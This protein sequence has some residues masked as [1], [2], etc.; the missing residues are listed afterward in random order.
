MKI[1]IKLP[2]NRGSWIWL[3]VLMLTACSPAAPATFPPTVIP[4][5][6]STPQTVS[7][8]AQVQRVEVQM[9]PTNPSQASAVVHG[10]L[11]ESCAKLG[12]SQVQYALHTFQIRVYAL[13]P[14][15]IG[16][17]PV[18]TPF[19]TIIPLDTKD[20]PAGRYTIIANGVY[21]AFTIPEEDPTATSI[22][23]VIV[24]P[25]GVTCSD[26]ATF[27]SD[28]TI[29]DNSLLG[30]NAA[31]KKTW[32]VKNTGTCTWD[33]SYLVAY[34]SGATM[35]QQPGYWI[36]PPGQTVAPGQTADVSV[37]MTSPVDNGNYVAYWGL[38]KVNG[39]FMPVAGGANGN[40]FYVKIKVSNGTPEG[41]I[42]AQSI[43]I[44]LEQGS[45]AVCTANSTY[46]VNA[47]ITAN[48]PAAASYEINSTAGQIA[49]GN[50]QSSP[51]GPVGPVVTGTLVFDQADTKTI[52]YRFVGP[53][54]Y[55]NDITINLKVNDGEWQ[56]TKLSCQ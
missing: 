6:T 30:P 16:C 35:S 1:I 21:A 52:N 28:V 53:Y 20:L 31:F 40:S 37:G 49:A 11:T 47:S 15:D 9:S 38:K 2:L 32:R 39:P 26:S 19:E 46:F 36:V 51:T 5:V 24:A 50:F 34:I 8:E 25:T 56:N 43:S 12:E 3:F 4:S 10:V 27:M 48:G 54:P 44:E 7:R 41:K 55:P 42:T 29:P 14:G 33:S 23:T 17:A 45:G 18:T 13:S 22:P